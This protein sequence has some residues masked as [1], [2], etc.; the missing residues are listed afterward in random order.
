M[1]D[2][3]L[4]DEGKF[5]LNTPTLPKVQPNDDTWVVRFITLFLPLGTLGKKTPVNFHPCFRELGSLDLK[6]AQQRKQILG[7]SNSCPKL[8]IE[9]W[10]WVGPDLRWPWAWTTF[11]PP[12]QIWALIVGAQPLQCSCRPLKSSPVA[13][14]PNCATSSKV[15]SKDKRARS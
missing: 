3:V 12:S 11:K 14:T 5:H 13:Y 8:L 2:L 9:F 10:K 4:L 15:R 7:S 6:K 1:W